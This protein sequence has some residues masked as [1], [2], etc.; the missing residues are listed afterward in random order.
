MDQRLSLWG[1]KGGR[2][3]GVCDGAARQNVTREEGEKMEENARS[4]VL[5]GS[6][7]GTKAGEDPT[8]GPGGERAANDIIGRRVSGA[9]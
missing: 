3:C 8:V 7:Q 1:R 6:L 2:V 5:I 9:A 4:N